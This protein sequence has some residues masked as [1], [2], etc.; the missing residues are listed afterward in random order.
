[1]GCARWPPRPVNPSAIDQGSQCALFLLVVQCSASPI[2]AGSPA[3]GEKI[4]EGTKNFSFT[5]TH[6]TPPSYSHVPWWVS[7]SCNNII[8]LTHLCRLDGQVSAGL[9]QAFYSKSIRV[10]SSGGAHTGG[11][12]R[13]LLTGLALQPLHQQEAEGRQPQATA[14]NLSHER[15]PR[16]VGYQPRRGHH[17]NSKTPASIK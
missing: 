12:P 7:P 10:R 9:E 13:R 4:S 14:D 15:R 6:A 3:S 8:S 5:T 16:T 1:M 11:R 17:K 2:R